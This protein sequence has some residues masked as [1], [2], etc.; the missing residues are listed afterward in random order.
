MTQV[1]RQWLLR[2]RPLGMVGPQHFDLVESPMPEPDLAAGQVLVKTLMLGFDPAMRGWLEDVLSYLP[3]VA[4]GE[5]MRASGVGQVT[6]WVMGEQDPD[7]QPFRMNRA[8]DGGFVA[9]LEAWEGRGSATH[10]QLTT[11]PR[12]AT[13]TSSSMG[14]LVSGSYSFG[15]TRML[16]SARR[17]PRIRRSRRPVKNFES[18]GPR[19]RL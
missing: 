8:P 2:E 15:G 3:P 6:A 1:N 19:E 17:A 5:P 14:S 4:I 12:S 10:A 11:S 9:E 7:Y 18:S 13:S 16:P